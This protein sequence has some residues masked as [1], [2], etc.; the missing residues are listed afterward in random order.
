MLKVFSEIFNLVDFHFGSDKLKAI[1]NPNAGGNPVKEAFYTLFM[2]FYELMIKENKAP[3]DYA[4][5]KSSLKNIGVK[6]QGFVL[7]KT[8]EGVV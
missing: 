2:A 8:F 4:K 6:F 5:I 1:V 3:F 7:Q